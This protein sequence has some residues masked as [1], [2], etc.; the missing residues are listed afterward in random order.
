MIVLW[1]IVA[2]LVIAF[3]ILTHEL[4]HYFAAKWCGIKVDQ[5]SIGFG[6]EI[7]GWD[8]G[9]TRYSLKWIL[10]GGSV[11]IAGM[12]PEEEVPEEDVSRSYYSAPL[13]KRA[14]V[15]IAGSLVHILIAFMLFYLFFWPL[16]YEVLTGRIGSV[17]KTVQVSENEKAPGPGY[18]AGLRRGDLITSVNG[19]A[20]GD[21]SELTDELASRPGEKVELDYEHGK[22][23]P[24]RVTS[25]T[26]L[27]V[28]GRGILGVRVDTGDTTIVRSNPLAAIGQSARAL[29]QVTVALVEGIGSLFSV[30]TLKMLIGQAPRS[31][32]GPRSIVGAA[33]LTFQAAGQ[34][35]SVFIFMM[36]QLFLFLALFNLIPLPPFDGGHLLLTGIEWVS[37]KRID[38]RKLVP[39]AWVVIV[40]LSLIALRLMLLD[41]FNPLSNP[42]TP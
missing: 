8:R 12:N 17:Q 20:V 14:F 18:E 5:F 22:D 23:G 19:N 4:G 1:I 35:F 9:E 30:N 28:E 33:Q 26:L 3:M 31:Q 25:A 38:V 24:S 41:I 13:W 37:G 7:T 40:V 15:V 29:G 6:P 42:F 34:G 21:W 11:K 2:V 36:A 16:G 39:V 27:D 10:A 32:E